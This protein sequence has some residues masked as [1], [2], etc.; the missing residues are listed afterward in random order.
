M[1]IDSKEY[2]WLNEHRKALL[3][4][5]TAKQFAARCNEIG[6]GSISSRNFGA[7]ADVLGFKVVRM[8]NGALVYSN[9][10]G[11]VPRPQPEL[12]PSDVKLAALLKLIRHCRQSGTAR[13]LFDDMLAQRPECYRLGISPRSIVRY[14]QELGLVRSGKRGMVAV[15][16]NTNHKPDTI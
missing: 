8:E 10:D 3:V 4:S 1:V 14:C 6:C 15:W 16:T 12:K 5:G 2:A 7:L 13:E 9:P 11:T